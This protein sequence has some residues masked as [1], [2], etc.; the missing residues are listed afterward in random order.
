M[1]VL[2]LTVAALV[3][4]GTYL[5][6]QAG[7]V[8]II[9]GITLLSHGANLMLLA[10][11]VSAW[12][13]EPLGAEGSSRSADPL[14]MAFVLTAIVITLAVTVLMLALARIGGDDDTYQ[15]PDTG[16]DHHG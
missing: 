4:G 6:L 14:P 9:F 16:E 5:L 3:A 8:R 15:M 11:G 13:T 2:P 10:A 12:R 7:L 1:S